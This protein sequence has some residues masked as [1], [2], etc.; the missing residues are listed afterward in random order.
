MSVP[1]AVSRRKP[2]G[3]SDAAERRCDYSSGT[4]ESFYERISRDLIEEHGPLVRVEYLSHFPR[5]EINF[6]YEDGTAIYSGQRTGY[7]DVHFLTLG[8]V[9]EGPRYAQHF[10]LAA[11]FSLTPDQIESIRPGDVIVLK[12]G[13]PQVVRKGQTMEAPRN[14]GPSTGSGRGG[15]IEVALKQFETATHS[16]DTNAAAEAKAQLKRLG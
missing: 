13:K 3:E 10:L 8:Y 16:F 15:T 2:K 9:G 6:I 14:S 7:H 11:G 1:A 4:I 5:F 12:D